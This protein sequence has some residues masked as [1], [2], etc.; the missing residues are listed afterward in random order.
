[1]TGVFGLGGKRQQMP[2]GVAWSH[3]NRFCNEVDDDTL[4]DL[5]EFILL[6]YLQL[7]AYSMLVLVMERL[8]YRKWEWDAWGVL[9]WLWQNPRIKRDL[10]PGFGR[11]ILATRG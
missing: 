2:C 8:P 10:S 6:V 3:A 5:F 4:H 11:C 7:N 1:M 9:M